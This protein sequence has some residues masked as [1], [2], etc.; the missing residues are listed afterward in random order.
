MREKNEETKALAR[1]ARKKRLP[2]CVLLLYVFAALSLIC[3]GFM[4]YY[5]I[6][7]VR[8]Y[9]ESYG[10]SMSDGIAEV[11]QYVISGSGIYLG[12][13]VLFWAAGLILFRLRAFEHEKNPAADEPEKQT[14]EPEKQTDEAEEAN[15]PDEMD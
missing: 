1:G 14:D 8:S 9:Y 3:A 11:M 15:E 5:S 6:Q 13:A 7:Y 2:A 12:F 4:L 10:M